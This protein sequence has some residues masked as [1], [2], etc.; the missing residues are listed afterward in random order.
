MHTALDAMHRIGKRVE[1]V[2]GQVAQGIPTEPGSAASSV[3]ESLSRLPSLKQEM[4]ANAAV[5]RTA[6]ELLEVFGQL[7]NAPRR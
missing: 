3:L 6:D 5:V 4:R 2:A 7:L 1:D